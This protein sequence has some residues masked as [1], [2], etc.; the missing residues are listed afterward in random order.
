MNLAAALGEPVVAEATLTPDDQIMAHLFAVHAVTVVDD[1]DD[2]VLAPVV[3]WHLHP[4]VLGV[5]VPRVG[6]QL[7]DGRGRA[8]VQLR[9]ELLYEAAAK[10]QLKRLAVL[11][12]LGA[13][14]LGDVDAHTATRPTAAS[15]DAIA[16]TISASA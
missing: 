12:R 2:G 14:G 7:G 13:L 10:E 16:F 8:W 6:D 5:G 9:A 11:R 3:E 15:S 4:D 1:L